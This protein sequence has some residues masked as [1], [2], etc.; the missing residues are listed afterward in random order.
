[1]LALESQCLLAV[2]GGVL[3]SEGQSRGHGTRPEEGTLAYP[4]KDMEYYS[5]ICAMVAQLRVFQSN[6]KSLLKGLLTQVA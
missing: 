4:L 2:I 6:D 3:K 1:M 5:N